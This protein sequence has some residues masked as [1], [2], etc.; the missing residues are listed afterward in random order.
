MFFLNNLR[1]KYGCLFRYIWS[2]L[3][4]TSL[5]IDY[6]VESC[7]IAFDISTLLVVLYLVMYRV[8][9]NIIKKRKPN[10]L[11]FCPHRLFLLSNLR[12]ASL[13]YE[14]F[15]SSLFVFVEVTYCMTQGVKIAVFPLTDCMS[16]S[17]TYN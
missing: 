5:C 10:K 11:L 3:G 9:K 2:H 16:V 17:S 12:L 7:K 15:S 6:P 13:H 14:Y 4:N 8:L 1:L